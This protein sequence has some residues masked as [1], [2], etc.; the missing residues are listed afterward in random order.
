MG[1]AT[2]FPRYIY[3]AKE[4]AGKHHLDAHRYQGDG[5]DDLPQAVG[6]GQGPELDRLPE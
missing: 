1:I 6:I 5:R 4:E 3:D 2:L